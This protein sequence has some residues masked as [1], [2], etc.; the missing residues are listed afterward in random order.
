[1][2]REDRVFIKLQIA[3]IHRICNLGTST[4]VQRRI[5][6]MCSP[7]MI[8]M[9]GGTASNIPLGWLLCDGSLVDVSQ[10]SDL[11]SA[12]GNNFGETASSSQF[13]LPDLRGRFIR[14]VDDGAGRDPDVASRTDMKNPAVLSATVASVQSYAFQNHVHPYTMFPFEEDKSNPIADG[15]YWIQGTTNTGEVDSTQ[16]NVSSETRPLN[17]YAYFFIKY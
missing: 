15:S 13:Y 1:M 6:A 10:Y 16:Y 2:L 12:I 8:M 14:G 7:G 17:A 5:S 9:W 3:D 11:Y 4:K